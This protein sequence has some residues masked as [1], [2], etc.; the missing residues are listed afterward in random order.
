MDTVVLDK[1]GTLTLGDPE[2]VA[3]HPAED[4]TTAR[5]GR[6]VIWQNFAGTLLV[7]GLGMLLAAL[8]LLNPLL[9]AFI[10]VSSEL[11]FIL[12]STAPV[13]GASALRAKA[14]RLIDDD[15]TCADLEWLAPRL[16]TS[17]PTPSRCNAASCV[18]C[19][20]C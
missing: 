5:L 16:R 13:A 19:P 7:D 9:A 18:T 20:A 17:T 8:S 1:T 15:L 3:V 4:V 11:A 12:N 6:A 2:V 14:L 10:H